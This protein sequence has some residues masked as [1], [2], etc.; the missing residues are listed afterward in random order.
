MITFIVALSV[1]VPGY[2]LY[3]KFIDRIDG[4]DSQRVTP[5]M[6]MADGVDYVPMPWWRISLIQFLNIS[7]LPN[8]RK[9]DLKYVRRRRRYLV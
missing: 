1:L 7:E 9:I 4:S 2:M 5:A 3:L 8:L 6:T